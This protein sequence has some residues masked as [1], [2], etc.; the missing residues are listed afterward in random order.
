M[1]ALVS[2]NR[3]EG[4]VFAALSVANFFTKNPART[5]VPGYFN[6]QFL[7][8]L[9]YLL[10]V[11]Q[12]SDPH[13]VNYIK[14]HN[15]KPD[16]FGTLNG[17]L[18]GMAAVL[19]RYMIKEPVYNFARLNSER[20]PTYLMSFEYEGE[21]SFFNFLVPEDGRNVIK[22]GVA[23]SDELLYLFFT[24]VFN[25]GKHSHPTAIIT[26]LLQ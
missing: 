17:I 12:A 21:F 19:G 18:P 24:G 1:P 9:L 10:Q 11:P 4:T 6:H 15:F 26:V 5:S 25:L 20:A 2:T 3:D 7:V 16:E 13:F 8:D 23:H 22:H 14:R